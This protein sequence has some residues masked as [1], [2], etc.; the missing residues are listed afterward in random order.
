MSAICIAVERHVQ[1]WGFVGL[2]ATCT[3]VQSAGLGFVGSSCRVAY[4]AAGGVIGMV[5]KI[6]AK[7]VLRL[8]AEGFSGRQIAAQGMSRHRGL[9][10]PSSQGHWVKS[11][12]WQPWATVCPRWDRQGGRGGAL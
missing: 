12:L 9:S 8:R 1:G 3:A 4:H 2:S 11:R 10:P 6:L 7:L 5:R